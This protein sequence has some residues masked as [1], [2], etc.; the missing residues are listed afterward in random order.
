MN[1]ALY[2]H[3][4]IRSVVIHPFIYP[5]THQST[6]PLPVYLFV[7]P[8]VQLQC[9]MVEMT[10]HFV[11]FFLQQVEEKKVSKGQNGPKSPKIVPKMG[12]FG[13]GGGD[14]S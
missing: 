14:Q 11:L 7:H 10:Y 2:I 5:F 1:L 8:V 4:L 6:C 12:F 3:L 13:R 9:K